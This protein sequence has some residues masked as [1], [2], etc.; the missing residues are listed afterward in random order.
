MLLQISN[1]TSREALD[2]TVV[3]GKINVKR[4][5]GKPREM[6]LDRFR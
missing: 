5:I 3:A 4:G 6:M 2:N 1:F